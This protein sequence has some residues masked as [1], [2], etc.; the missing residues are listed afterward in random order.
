MVRQFFEASNEQDTKRMDQLV[1]R[2]N[3]SFHFSGMP[4]PMDWN[5]HKQFLSPFTIA[6]PDLRLNIEDMVA[7]GNKVAVRVTAGGTHKGELQGISPTDKQV[8][9]TTMDFLTIIDGKVTEEWAT[10]DITG[11]MQQIGAMPASS[12]ANSNAA[13]S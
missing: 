11:L 2:T 7:E 10:A 8:T 1:S 12:P 13:S 6:F 4:L 5:Q 9:F 3:Y